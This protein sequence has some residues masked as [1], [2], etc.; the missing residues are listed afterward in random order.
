MD[1]DSLTV[2]EAKQL[3]QMFGASTLGGH[4]YKIGQ[5]YHIRTVT[6]HYTGRLVEVYEHE[7]VI[8]DAAWIADDGR[9]S[10]ALRSG[11]LEEIEPYPGGQ[12]IIGRGAL[13]DAS[14]WMR[15]LP[16]TVK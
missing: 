2:G 5:A 10:E 12:A 7:L 3:A 13:I 9:F 1:I 8:D 16:R 4:P 15:D 6:H 11:V 14:E